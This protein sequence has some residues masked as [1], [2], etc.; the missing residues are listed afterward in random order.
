MP[1]QLDAN[2]ELFFQRELEVVESQLYNVKY[3]NLKARQLIP[4][5][6]N[7]PRGTEQITYKQYD[8]LGMA[9]I[10]ANY[11]TD[12]PRV[13][14]KGKR[15]TSPVKRLADSY[16][17]S[18]DDI[19]AA[20]MA[21]VPLDQMEA[22]AAKR[23]ID[24]LENKIA[25]FG[26]TDTGLPGLFTNVNIPS[27]LV[28]ADGDTTID[29]NGTQWISKAPSQIIRDFGAAIT[30]M[31]DLTNGVEL[32]DTALFPIAQLS[33]IATT[34]V[35]QQAPTVMILDVLKKA[36]PYIGV[37][38]DLIEL[39]TAGPD[40]GGSPSAMFV[41]YN[42]NPINLRMPIPWDFDQFPAQQKGLEY[43]IPCSEKVG[44]TIVSYPL[45]I[46]FT[47]GI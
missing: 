42:R 1:F 15:F 45:S 21:Q 25:Y 4:P 32:P 35:S 40:V 34:P 22:M 27:N 30:A 3:P 44:G 39:K 5:A 8:M 12:F 11:A 6:F 20:A 47:Y 24:Q 37:W 23:A 9:K 41:I 10:V 43:E 14:L 26:D 18:I 46:S 16:A 7:Y 31:R 19:E 36:H 13:S 28:T 33:Y 38:D 29:P 2:T 17:Y